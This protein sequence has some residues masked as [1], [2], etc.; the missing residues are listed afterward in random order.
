MKPSL[1]AAVITRRTYNRPLDD[2]TFETWEQTVDRVIGHQKWLWE[3]AQGYPL[4]FAQSSELDD[5]SNLMLERKVLT[6]GRTLWLGGTEISK[7]REASQFNCS[8]TQVET[9]MDVVDVL[10][11][12]LQGCGVGFR[13][14]VGQLTGYQKPVQK[15]TVIRSTRKEKG[16]V[17][18]NHET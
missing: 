17:Q 12:L 9:V 2:N 7:R 3:R 15:L 1:R 18:H 16:G 4:D 14:I 5:L 8:F 13:P 6:S 10:W 11:L